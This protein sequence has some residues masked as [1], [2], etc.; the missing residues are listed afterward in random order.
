MWNQWFIAL[1][2]LWSGVFAIL[3][4]QEKPQFPEPLNEDDFNTQLKSGLHVVEFYSPNCHHCKALAPTW[5]KTWETF[6]EEGKALHIAFSQVNCLLSGDLC[7]KEKIGYFPTIRLY[8]PSGVIK[9]FPDDAKRSM[10]NLIDFARREAN[11]PS[12]SEIVDIR[13]TSIQLSGDKVTQLLDGRGSQPILVSFWPSKTMRSTD[14]DMEFEN[15]ED[16]RPFQR[17]WRVLSSRLLSSSISTGHVNCES[18]AKLCEE[19]GF[20]DLVKIRNHSYERLP[21]VA[22]IIPGRKVNNLFIYESKFS[23]SVS[24]YEDFA[25]RVTRNS[26]APFISSSDVKQIAE[27]D[28]QLTASSA[29]ASPP[30]NLHI[31]FAYNP[32]TVV[33]EDFAVLDHLLEP[34]S[35]IPNAYLYKSID[36]MKQASRSNLDSLYKIMN[37]NLD[38][39]EKTIKEEFIDLNVMDQNPTFYIFRDGDRIPHLFPG[40]STTEVRDVDRIVT[41]I[42]SLS[43]PFMNEVSTS[44]FKALLNFIPEEYSGL[45]IQLID[46]S[47]PVQFEKSSRSLE[48]FMLAGYDYEDFRMEY[49]VN[50]TNAERAKKSKKMSDLKEKGASAKKRI[51]AAIQDV[52]HVD[53]NKV[54]LGYIDISK[55]SNPLSKMGLA[56]RGDTYKAGDVIIINKVTKF[57]YEHDAT[58]GVLTSESSSNIKHALVSALLPKATPL[59]PRISGHLLSTPFGDSLRFLDSLHQFGFFGYLG[60]LSVVLLSYKILRFYSRSRVTRK[61]KAKRNTLGILGKTNQKK[62]RD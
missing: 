61:Y 53:D 46:T 8:G 2:L 30:Q 59:S 37:S 44:N 49:V 39:P 57:V 6:Y 45:A 58:G 35:N 24:D 5:E 10:E 15:C 13:S 18:S 1:Y 51:Q 27:R 17:T 36:D 47:S 32:K 38:G 7:A 29:F 19:L 20:D 16:C 34:L 3:E 31:V 54:V 50:V 43:L 26:E 14:D 48:K 11:D 21:R 33:Q 40:Y 41:W 60:L 56:H 22:L 55:S 25:T 23:T 62:L 52:P 4:Q 28:F 12:N 42:E 9:N